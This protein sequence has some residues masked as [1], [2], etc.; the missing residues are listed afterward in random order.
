[1]NLYLFGSR[2]K[3]NQRSDS[4]HDFM[5]VFDSGSPASYEYS[6]PDNWKLTGD[7]KDQLAKKGFTDRIDIFTNRK[8][9][10]DT[11]KHDKN[12][13]SYQCLHNGIKFK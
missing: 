8:N 9:K 7:L 3:G 10:F 13:I 6:H 4:D 12:S 2:A 1:M 5:V 11:A